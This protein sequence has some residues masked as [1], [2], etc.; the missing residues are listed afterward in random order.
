MAGFLAAC[1]NPVL[2]SRY[3]LEFPELPPAW[4]AVL[5]PPSWKVEWKRP[6]GTTERAF[7]DGNGKISAGLSH[8]WPNPVYA[9]P[10]WPGLEPGKF[11]PAG[12]VYPFD[13]DG[14]RLVLSWRGGVDAVF[15]RELE[16][17]AAAAVNARPLRR[18]RFFNW[19]RFRNV[20][21]KDIPPE[22]CADLWL[23]NWKETAKTTISASFQARFVKAEN[24]ELV[25]LQIPGDGPWLS[26]S[27]F[28]EAENWRA[29]DTAAFPLGGAAE[30]WVCPA[31]I[32][33]LSKTERL[34]AP[35]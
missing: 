28:R 19:S 34:W 4:T 32:M 27:P 5:G 24:R 33:I 2:P 9:W 10:Y 8:E 7:Y 15:Y 31:G 3:T 29:G 14:D 11:R 26:P 21:N 12:A 20:I 30:T 16:E 22:L 23:V 1:V 17:A 6:D 18:P 25:E 35:R 13:V